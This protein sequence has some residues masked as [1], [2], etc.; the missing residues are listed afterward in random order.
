MT[1]SRSGMSFPA[2]GTAKTKSL[3]LSGTGE[4][5]LGRKMGSFTQHLL[6]IYSVPGVCVPGD[7][8]EYD[9]YVWPLW[10]SPM[11]KAH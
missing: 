2:K 9:R 8:D 4:R 6:S 5:D 11:E 7:S 10:G 3:S 1:D